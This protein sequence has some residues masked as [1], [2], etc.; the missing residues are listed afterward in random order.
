MGN[1][2]DALEGSDGMEHARRMALRTLGIGLCMVAPDGRVLSADDTFLGMFH[3]DRSACGHITLNDL[4]LAGVL[5]SDDEEHHIVARTGMVTLRNRGAPPRLVRVRTLSCSDPDEVQL[6]VEEIRQTAYGTDE[7]VLLQEMF[8]ALQ[9]KGADILSIHDLE[10]RILLYEGPPE[11]GLTPQ[12]MVGRTAVD[13]L[14]EGEGE[15]ILEQLLSV[16]RTGEEQT[17]ENSVVRDGCLQHFVDFLYPFYDGSGEMIAIGKL[18]RNVTECREAEQK[19]R[20]SEARYRAIVQAMPDA[21]FRRTRDGV[22]LYSQYA[23][24]ALQFVL[25]DEIAGSSMPV[26]GL[27][28]G[29]IEWSQKATED[30]LDTGE[31]QVFERE[32]STLKRLPRLRGSRR[33][34]RR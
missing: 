31:M 21:M 4:G 24:P 29:I 18:N 9:R 20:E 12:E 27:P 25:H 34:Q 11:Y 1:E 32:I 10:G 28:L 30:A 22:C 16:A 26:C 19:L 5:E 6:M 14:P 7:S 3:T 2:S 15:R 13:L 23:D 33:A 17:F 8:V